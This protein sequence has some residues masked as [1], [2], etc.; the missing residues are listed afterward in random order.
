MNVLLIVHNSLLVTWLVIS[1]PRAQL[2][3]QRIQCVRRNLV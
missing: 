1:C 3:T 2:L